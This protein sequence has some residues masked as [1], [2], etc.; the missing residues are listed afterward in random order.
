MRK[1][2]SF[3]TTNCDARLLVAFDDLY[4]YTSMATRGNR[5]YLCNIRTD[6]QWEVDL[7]TLTRFQRL[8][9]EGETEVAA[10]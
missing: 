5:Y 1:R 6:L 2:F 3:E 4:A 7:V 9:L 8:V 10:A